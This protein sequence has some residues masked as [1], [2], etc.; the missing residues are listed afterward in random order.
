MGDWGL[1]GP[2]QGQVRSRESLEVAG[3]PVRWVLWERQ[4]YKFPSLLAP[5]CLSCPE[6]TPD[7]S[8]I[9]ASAYS[10]VNAYFI[11]LY[12]I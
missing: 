12:L 6:P 4:R 11:K 2:W 5:A 8:D 3:R 7:A 10:F 1:L 9:P